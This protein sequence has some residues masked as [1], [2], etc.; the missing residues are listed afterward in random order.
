MMKT[1]KAKAKTMRRKV[2]RPRLAYNVGPCSETGCTRK[3]FCRGVCRNH[4]RRLHYIEHERARRGHTET[5]RIPIGGKYH[6]PRTGYVFVKVAQR[7]F[8]LEHRLVMEIRLGRKL[9]KH[10]T[11]HHK[12]G[13]RS[14]N[15]FSNLE[16][17]STVHPKGQR[18][19]DLISFAKKILKNYGSSRTEVQRKK[20]RK[21]R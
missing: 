7:K 10:E 20:R 12:N 3:A 1:T 16:L 13:I 18:V 15:R 19:R 9:R 17:W 2:G 21:Q 14:D 4:Y 11:V 5:P 8:V 6:N